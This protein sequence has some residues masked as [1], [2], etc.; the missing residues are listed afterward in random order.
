MQA[1]VKQAVVAGE[2]AKNQTAGCQIDGLAQVH[3]PFATGSEARG[4]ASA[5]FR[6]PFGTLMRLQAY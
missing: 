4:A 6:V 3:T 5:R 1:A 2:A